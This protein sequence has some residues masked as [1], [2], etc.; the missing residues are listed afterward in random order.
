MNLHQKLIAVRKAVPYLQKDSRNLQFNYSFVSNSTI[1]GA[2]RDEMDKQGLILY[3]SIGD[4]KTQKDGKMWTVEAEM[5]MIW[6]N[7]DKPD[8]TLAVPWYCSGTNN[9][10]A[11]AYGSGL[12]Y[13]IKYFILKFFNIA[14]DDDD[15]DNYTRKAN[16][17]KPPK[18]VEMITAAHHKT[19]E[20]SIT[21]LS[22]VNNLD[23]MEFRNRVKSFCLNKWHVEHFFKEDVPGME[24]SQ[25]N[26]LMKQL[27]EFAKQMKIKPVTLPKVCAN[28]GKESALQATMLHGKEEFICFSCYDASANDPGEI[29]KSQR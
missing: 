27:G 28:C 9:D 20:A 18:P 26:I 11:K 12:T 21:N 22:K 24:L 29:D 1:V 17:R 10:I 4:K 8:E 19:L 6:V 13:A 5:T 2:I 15:P 25:Y 7:A 14:T 23:P 16:A 3:P